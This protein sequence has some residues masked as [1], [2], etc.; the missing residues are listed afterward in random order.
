MRESEESQ[1]PGIASWTDSCDT[2]DHLIGD[3]PVVDFRKSVRIYGDDPA[4]VAGAV[5][6][7]VC[8]APRHF[9]QFWDAF[10]KGDYAQ[11]ADLAR[12][13][14]TIPAVTLLKRCRRVLRDLRQW[15]GAGSPE[16]IRMLLQMLMDE[17]DAV[18]S[19]Y[20]AM[21]TAGGDAGPASDGENSDP[22][23]SSTGGEIGTLECP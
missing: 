16:H 5:E 10:E 21:R 3:V 2:L 23:S 15:A 12:R 20:A 17:Y 18:E 14:E 1:L 19:E 4:L 13:M 9:P 7:F 8:E 6:Q 11:L 22:E